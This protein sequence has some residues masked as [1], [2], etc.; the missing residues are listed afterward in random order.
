MSKLVLIDTSAWIDFFRN[1]E[2]VAAMV[3]RVLADKRGAICGMIDLEIR[4]GLRSD[5]AHVLPALQASYRVPT[6]EADYTL[7]G[8][9]LASLRR[10]GIT[11]PGSDGLIAHLAVRHGLALLEN[12]GHFKQVP[13]LVRLRA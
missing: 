9:M 6:E 7:A 10:Q 1:R 2:P 3:D 12:D 8:D 5:E 4:Q 13:N 11:V